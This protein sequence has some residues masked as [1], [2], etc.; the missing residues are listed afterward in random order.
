MK[1]KLGNYIIAAFIINVFAIMS[2]GGV[3]ILLVTDM[4]HN[5]S[6]LEKESEDVSKIDNINK[7]IHQMISSIHHAIIHDDKNEFLVYARSYA[8]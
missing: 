8:R 6:R 5:I 1:R 4:V 2:V 3:C 7:K